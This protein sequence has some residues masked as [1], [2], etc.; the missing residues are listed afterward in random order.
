MVFFFQDVRDLAQNN[1]ELRKET[2]E[3]ENCRDQIKNMVFEMEVFFQDERDL[4]QN[5]EE[6]R[7]E[8]KELENC[9]DQ[10]KNMVFDS[11]AVQRGQ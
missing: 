5:N 1:E 4:A 10:L 6:L 11:M 9:R 3:L 7:K 2:K 8:T